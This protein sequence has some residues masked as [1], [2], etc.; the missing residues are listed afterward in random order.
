MWWCLYV[1]H[2]KVVWFCSLKIWLNW[3]NYHPVIS[4]NLQNP[5][6]DLQ[7]HCSKHGHLKCIRNCNQFNVKNLRKILLV[8]CIITSCE[9]LRLCVDKSNVCIT[10][11]KHEHGSPKKSMNVTN[12]I[13][14]RWNSCCSI[15]TWTRVCN[16]VY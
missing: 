13:E 5:L 16:I 4:S 1:T 3:I 12:S 6:K 14:I 11:K 7:K 10:C 8:M 2:L 9:S 15:V